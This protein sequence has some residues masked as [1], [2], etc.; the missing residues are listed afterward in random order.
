[1]S[2]TI[3]VAALRELSAQGKIA[4]AKLREAQRKSAL[5]RD[6]NTFCLSKPEIAERLKGYAMK[7]EDRAWITRHWLVPSGSPM[8]DVV[9]A[10]L[11][12]WL[13]THRGLRS[14]SSYTEG[15]RDGPCIRVDWDA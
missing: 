1:M 12:A 3:D 8:T 9:M 10:Q 4:E 2:E 6:H 7:G 15:D 14:S 11:V 13:R 5:E